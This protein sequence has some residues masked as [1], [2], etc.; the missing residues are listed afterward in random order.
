MP[1]TARDRRE[2]RRGVLKV[3]DLDAAVPRRE[4]E[5]T[6]AREHECATRVVREELD[7]LERE[8]EIYLVGSGE[9]AEVRR[10]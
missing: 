1:L 10:T 5:Q 6:V 7:R 8:G 3:A 9:T 2:V 4:L